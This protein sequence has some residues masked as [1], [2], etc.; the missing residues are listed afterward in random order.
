MQAIGIPGLGRELLEGKT[1]AACPGFE[2]WLLATRRRL[3]GAAEGVLREAARS[4]L[5][6][7]DG[8]RA[9][10]LASRLVAANPLDED[11]QEL[12]IRA[13]VASGDR[14]AA[15]IQ[16]DACVA[17]FRRELGTDPGDGRPPRRGPGPAAA[18]APRPAGEPGRDGGPP[19]GGPRR[20]RRRSGGRRDRACCDRRSPRPTTWTTGRCRCGRSWRSARRWSTPSGAA[21]AKAPGS[22]TRRSAWPTGS[23]RRSPRPRRTG[24]SATS[25]CCGG[26]TTAR[27]GGS[28]LRRAGRRRA[29]R[30]RVGAGVPGRGLDR[31]RPLRGRPERVRGGD[32]PDPR[33]RPTQVDAWVWTFTGRIHL[34]RGDARAGARLPDQGAARP[35]GAPLDGVRAAARGACS[36]TSISPRAGSTR[37]RRLR[38]RACAGAAVGRPVLGGPRGSRAGP[39]R[40]A[41]GRRGDGTAVDH[42]GTRSLRSP[43]RR[44]PVGRGLLPRRALHL[45]LE[46]RRVEAAQ[47][48]DD[49]EALAPAPGCA[50]SS[51][52]PTPT[53]A[54]L[55]TGPRPRRRGSW[56]RRSTT[57]RCR[58]DG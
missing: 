58:F 52:A 48:I 45:A 47:W 32:A 27:S 57:R 5:S 30:A 54:G 16:R 31:R 14:A 15:E 55:A 6:A 40:G 34:L 53:V 44:L 20:P 23:G 17:L 25:S 9:A 56:P 42:R 33:G 35:R 12:L 2:A 18:R 3:A 26:A 37:R 11:A 1:F 51:P 46:H 22:C 8:A 24:S 43:A 19:R 28:A 39:G 36:P 49:L 50:S 41:P 29:S 13:Y 38:A 4:K 7:G 21:T 10:D